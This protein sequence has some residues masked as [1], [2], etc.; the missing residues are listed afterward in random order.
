[1]SCAFDRYINGKS[2]EF[3]SS[4]VENIRKLYLDNNYTQKEISNELGIDSRIIRSAIL[5]N[6]IKKSKSQHYKRIVDNSKKTNLNKYGTE[7]SLNSDSS[8]VK[9]KETWINKYGVDN[10]SKSNIIKKKKI[11][12]SN[13]HYGVDYPVQSDIIKNNIKNTNLRV[14]G[15]TS[16]MKLDKYR[17]RQR[18]LYIPENVRNIIYDRDRFRS[19]L[20]DIGN[21]L[22][23]ADICNKLEYYSDTTIRRQF[24]LFEFDKEFK[25]LSM[26]VSN[27]E[28]EVKKYI[29][30]L[31]IN[32]LSNVRDI[33]NPYEL[34]I[35]I[36]DINIAIEFNGMYWH[37]E[38]QVNNDYHYKKS[39][40]AN[41]KGIF[42]YHIWENEWNDTRVRKI[43]ESQ[44][45]NLLKMNSRRIYARSCIIKEIST[46]ECMDF[47]NN[48]HIQGNRNSRVRYGLF[49]SSELVSVMTFGIDRFIDKSNNWQLLRFCN[50]LDTSV[51]GGAS[52]LFKKFIKDYDPDK[53]ISYCDISKGTGVT[54]K[55]LGFNLNSITPCNYIWWSPKYG[56]KTRYQ[57]QMKDEFKIM[58]D[59]G[60]I[61]VF[62][63]GNYKFV[64][65]KCKERN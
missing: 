17:F 53:V 5:K 62:N 59:M 35:Y 28:N 60:Y 50:K 34:D 12:T 37:S 45:R 33:I 47:L 46:K 44:I 31:G 10:P 58:T 43:I 48:N 30:S 65:N 18:E 40:L 21:E 38:K 22:S 4:F 36:P 13:L 61:R 42:I 49:Y 41:G 63:C 15:E 64:Y 9:K 8:I 51:V 6:N 26:H 20:L 39:L 14:Y 11:E 29:E 24:F 7:C 55:K 32:Y 1:M 25:L 2:N 27:E 23:I 57:C 56:I 54:Y 19:L 52:K 3:V 16:H